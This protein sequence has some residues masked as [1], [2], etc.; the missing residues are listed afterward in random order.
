MTQQDTA[1]SPSAKRRKLKANGPVKEIATTKPQTSLLKGLDRAISPPLI[2]RRSP[3]P[4]PSFV[5]TW[6]FDDVP[7]S[8]PAQPPTDPEQLGKEKDEDGGTRFIPSPI[9]LTRIM[10][11]HGHQN[12][13]T[14]GLNDL[15][16]DP[17]IKECWNF[18]FL[19]DLEFV[20]QHFDRDVRDMVKV[21]IVHGF[22]KRDDANRISLLETAER[23]PNIE[24]LSAY[25]PDP[26][27]THHSK[28]LVLFR[29]DDT[30]QIIIHTANMIHRD[31]ANMTQAVWVSPQLPLLSRASQSQS[32][33]NTNPI[34]SGERFKS[35]LLRYIG[36]YEKRLKGLIAQLE[37]YDFSS[38][39]AAFIGS[40]PSRQKPGRAIPSTTSFGWLGLK[41]ILST[42]PISK[43]KAFSPPHIV[44]QV[45][46][47]ATLGA[48]PTWLS[49]LQ[50]VLSSY[51]KATT[52]VPE[53]TTVSFTKAS[54]FFTKRDDSVRIASSPKFSVIFPNPEE[55]RNS[56]DGYGSGGSIHWKLQSAQ[57]QKQLEYM[58]PMLCHWASTP[59]APALASTDVPRRE[60]HRGP[61]APHIKTYIRFSDDEQNTIDWAMLTSAN[62]SKQAW[63]DVVNKKEE[64]WIQ[65]WETGVV[66]WPALFAETTQAAVDEVV[67]VPMFGKDMPGVDDN[68]VNLEGKEAEE[69]RPKTIV[70]FRMPYDLPLKPYTADEKPWC[71][72]MA[73][74]EP[75][76][77]GH[78]WPGY[79]R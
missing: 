73:Y 12:V 54:S 60:A 25:I 78:A 43:A 40:V 49:N 66:V 22:W 61:A 76:R 70:G 1:G 11:L 67:M 9:Q 17:L 51:S 57:Q 69:M 62:L 10:K 42:I 65:S 46:S 29:H 79:G 71:A 75:D 56:L 19:F 23:Y 38:I 35:D 58:H 72:T 55:I 39:R 33:T 48:A 44:A 47:I 6:N 30:A 20:M 45:S 3:G 4:T 28:M 36:A 32:D 59:S 50:S 13:D 7:I 64:I 2:R 5:P 74:T 21:K 18:N 52:S 63:G 34:G 8:R 31:W 26:F 27:G 41:E 14:V 68:G 16:G 77:N 53:N 37:D 24:L 15:L